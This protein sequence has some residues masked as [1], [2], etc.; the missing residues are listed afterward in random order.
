MHTDYLG[1]ADLSDLTDNSNNTD[2]GRF[3]GIS[4]FQLQH[5]MPYIYFKEK[6]LKK[7]IHMV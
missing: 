6:N 5:K 3:S 4:T 7:V 1:N 2:T